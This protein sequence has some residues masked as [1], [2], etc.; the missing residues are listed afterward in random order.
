M[1]CMVRDYN[2]GDPNHTEGL[3]IGQVH[4]CQL[5]HRLPHLRIFHMS[6]H[7]VQICLVD[8]TGLLLAPTLALFVSESTG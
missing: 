2:Q 3:L 6:D 8:F 7:W 1:N 5:P 4:P